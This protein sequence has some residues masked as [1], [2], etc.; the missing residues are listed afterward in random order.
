MISTKLHHYID[1]IVEIINAESS[2]FMESGLKIERFVRVTRLTVVEGE[3]LIGAM[4]K[5]PRLG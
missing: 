5:F 1:G 3:I 2:D 4:E